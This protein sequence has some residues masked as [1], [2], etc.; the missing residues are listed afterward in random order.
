MK[1]H[2]TPVNIAY[3]ILTVVLLNSYLLVKA[4][5]YALVAIL[6]LFVWLNVLP[7]TRL[8]A[9]RR[10]KICSHGTVLLILFVCSLIPSILWHAVLAFLTIPHAY[11]DLVWSAVY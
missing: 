2:V 10:L 8:C 11:T 6:P 9:S 7:G 4:S 5:P 1:R 3:L